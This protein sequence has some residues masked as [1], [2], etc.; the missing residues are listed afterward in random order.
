MELSHKSED[1]LRDILDSL[2]EQLQAVREGNGREGKQREEGAMPPPP[3]LVVVVVVVAFHAAQ[4]K[5][6]HQQ[7]NHEERG[8]SLSHIRCFLFHPMKRRM[9]KDFENMH[10]YK[11]A[12]TVIRGRKR[13]RL[14]ERV[15]PH[16]IF[17][18]VYCVLSVHCAR[19]VLFF[20]H[21]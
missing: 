14:C 13:V 4:N 18:F 2:N 8:T 3:F 9:D 20:Q 17:L 6:Q 12:Q 11:G 7:M 16:L 5:Q 1:D 19:A 10:C 15:A 21:P